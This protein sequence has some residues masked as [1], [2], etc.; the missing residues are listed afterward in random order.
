ML[1]HAGLATTDMALT[2]FV[3]AAFVAA[4]CGAESSDLLPRGP[5]GAMVEL[6]VLSKFSALPFIPLALAA[7]LIWF[8]AG[9]AGRRRRRGG[10]RGGAKA[11][12]PFALAVLTGAVMVLSAGYR[13][14]FAG[15]ACLRR[16]CSPA[17][18][19]SDRARQE[20]PLR[21]LLGTISNSGWWYFFPVIL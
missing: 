7:A 16:S 17:S 13:F 11:G 14:S 8:L 19:G 3:A 5:V 10:D 12:L 4:M 6:A 21:H 2:A 9:G 1:A 15:E 18:A 20:R